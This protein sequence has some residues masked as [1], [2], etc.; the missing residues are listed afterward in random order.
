MNIVLLSVVTIISKNSC[1]WIEQPK[2]KNKYPLWPYCKNKKSDAERNLYTYMP[3]QLEKDDHVCSGNRVLRHDAVGILCVDYLQGDEYAGT[4]TDAQCCAEQICDT[5]TCGPNWSKRGNAAQISCVFD[6]NDETCCSPTANIPKHSSQGIIFIDKDPAQYS[7]G[8]KATII[9]ATDETD[10][11]GYNVYW[12]FAHSVRKV[13]S[14][15]LGNPVSWTQVKWNSGIIYKSFK[16]TG[17]DITF[18]VENNTKPYERCPISFDRKER[19]KAHTDTCNPHYWMVAPYNSFGVRSTLR[20]QAQQIGENHP[21]M[22]YEGDHNLPCA[23]GGITMGHDLPGPSDIILGQW[24]GVKTAAE[25][26]RLCREYSGPIPCRYWTWSF[27][28]NGRSSE[29]CWVESQSIQ[30]QHYSVRF[31]GPAVC[32]TPD[33]QAPT[34]KERPR[35]GSWQR[36]QNLIPFNHDKRKAYISEGPHIMQHPNVD[37][38]LGPYETAEECQAICD[39]DPL[40]VGFSFMKKDPSDTFFKHCIMMH[41]FKPVTTYS[42]FYDTWICSR[43]GQA[44]IIPGYKLHRGSDFGYKECSTSPVASTRQNSYTAC[45]NTCTAM[46]MCGYFTFATSE[47]VG[48]NCFLHSTCGNL[49]DRKKVDGCAYESCYDGYGKATYERTPVFGIVDGWPRQGTANELE[50]HIDIAPLPQSMSEDPNFKI[51]CV[52]IY[53]MKPEYGPTESSYNHIFRAQYSSKSGVIIN[54]EAITGGVLQSGWDYGIRCGIEGGFENQIA[55]LYQKVSEKKSDL[56]IVMPNPPGF[57]KVLTAKGQSGYCIPQGCANVGAVHEGGHTVLQ[58]KEKCDADNTCNAFWH[59][60]HDGWCTLKSSTCAN[61]RV[62]PDNRVTCWK[63]DS[64]TVHSIGT[65]Y[66]ERSCAGTCAWPRQMGFYKQNFFPTSNALGG[67]VV[68]S[69]N[70][71]PGLTLSSVLLLACGL[72]SLL[73]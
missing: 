69:G 24:N 32:P 25:C 56:W 9:R 19:T 61:Y 73:M 21:I 2:N 33:G 63:K 43:S 68:P 23:E 30:R 67:E 5:Y 29:S 31:V 46:K 65:S 50:I 71:A 13:P 34:G 11:D 8:G 3:E 22:D 41:S 26:A 4:C 60:S 59:R 57:S 35:C 62:N 52:A 12:G 49:I 37:T 27:P 44:P 1:G 36:Y 64:S 14:C 54:K 70:N 28:N 39:Q 17:C 6:C 15:G 72:L 58:C 47:T 45:A 51:W 18:T 48:S 42:V 40:C 7:Y 16:K 20:S 10:V 53:D 38:P 66:C 55:E